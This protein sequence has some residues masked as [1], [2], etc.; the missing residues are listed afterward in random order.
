MVETQIAAPVDGREPIS[1]AVVLAAVRAVPRHAF[2]PEQFRELAYADTPLP[3]GSGQTISQPYV[4]AKI[5]ALLELGPESRVLEVGVGSGYQAAVLAHITPHVF[6]VEI[7]PE[8]C[9]RARRDLATQGYSEVALRCGDG[10]FGWKEHAPFDGII[11]SCAADE[12][13]APLWEQLRPGGRIVIPLKTRGDFQELVVVAK[14]AAGE[15]VT[16]SIAPV[17]FVPLT[18]G[19]DGEESS[20]RGPRR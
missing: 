3:I 11:V 15:R 19:K 9:E 13:P 8:L 17:R 7:V 20:P 10:Y 6:G 14:T 16:R 4:V 5:T 1:S 12:V 2:V 18:R